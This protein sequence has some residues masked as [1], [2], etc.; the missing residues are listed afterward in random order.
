VVVV[1]QYKPVRDMKLLE[2]LAQPLHDRDY[3]PLIA[4]RGW[5]DIPGWKVENG[6][7]SESELDD[8]VAKAGC[9]LVPYREFYQSGI[10]VR[11]LE[12]GRAIV[13]PDHPFLTSLYGADWPGL[14][15]SDSVSSW[16]DAI[17][18]AI[19]VSND[20]LRARHGAYAAQV[21][22][23]WDDFFSRD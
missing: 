4:G 15:H 11:A 6:F 13:G 17:G 19:A 9:V 2:S 7:L 5:P 22:Q 12:A 10:A 23:Q 3:D 21:C 14:V 1:G 18:A 20:D 8:V 16:V